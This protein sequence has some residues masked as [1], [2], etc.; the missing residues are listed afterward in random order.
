MRERVPDHGHNISSGERWSTNVPVAP[1]APTQAQLFGQPRC[2]DMRGVRSVRAPCHVVAS[3]R[4][5]FGERALE[6]DLPIGDE[7][8]VR[9]SMVPVHQCERTLNT[10]RSFV[11][12]GG[13][14]RCSVS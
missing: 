3:S 6:E 2:K 10:A 13:N 14:R 11:R 8:D 1:I 12:A 7:L 9:L 4:G 5:G